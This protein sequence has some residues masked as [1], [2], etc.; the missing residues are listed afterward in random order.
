MNSRTFVPQD[1]PLLHVLC[2]RCKSRVLVFKDGRPFTSIER[3][4]AF[5]IA[6][7]RGKAC[8]CRPD[9]NHLKGL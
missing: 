3:A 6:W 1:L 8:G 2:S 9:D 5:I 4:S 7:A